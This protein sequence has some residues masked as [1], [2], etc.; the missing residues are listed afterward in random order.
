MGLEPRRR[1]KRVARCGDRA[2]VFFASKEEGASSV[3]S[4]SVVATFAGQSPAARE[5]TA[6]RNRARVSYF[7]NSVAEVEKLRRLREAPASIRF[8]GVNGSLGFALVLKR[9]EH[10]ENRKSAVHGAL[11]AKPTKAAQAARRDPV[12]VTRDE[13]RK[14]S[15]EEM[16]LLDESRVGS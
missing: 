15:V 13:R 8:A 10:R 2:N 6:R 1:R 9:H 3:K 16:L 4:A 7:E 11:A 14:T 12:P 5:D